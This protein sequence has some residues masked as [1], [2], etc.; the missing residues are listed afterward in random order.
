MSN[1]NL[2]ESMKPMASNLSEKAK[3]LSTKTGAA[4]SRVTRAGNDEHTGLMWYSEEEEERRQNRKNKNEK[5][6]D[7]DDGALKKPPPP[8]LNISVEDLDG[9]EDD[10][11]NSSYLELD[12][13]KKLSDLDALLDKLIRESSSAAADAARGTSSNFDR[14]VF[15]DGLSGGG[16]KKNARPRNCPEEDSRWYSHL[17]YNFANPLIKLGYKRPL[18]YEDLWDLKPTDETKESGQKLVEA[19][20][21]EQEAARKEWE[22]L[23]AARRAASEERET[24][25]ANQGR[26][27][28]E[29]EER[30]EMKRRNDEGSEKTTMD[31]WLGRLKWIQQLNGKKEKDE[32][33]MPPFL[34]RSLRRVYKQQFWRTFVLKL[35]HD[36]IMFLSPFI[37]ERL[38]HELN[39]VVHSRK[40]CF[41]LSLALLIC[42]IFENYFV[43]LYFIEL[44][45]M[46]MHLKS[47]FISLLYSKALRI[48]SAA[49]HS[50]GV[51]PIVN[52]QSNDASK[53]W[54]MPMYIHILWNG[55]FQILVVMGL[56]VRVM[57]WGPSFA[58][59]AVTITIIPA[60]MMSG[61]ALAASR[62]EQV[63]HTDAR[64]KL[65][66][67]VV[68]GIKAIK[69][70]AWENAYV[71]RILKLREQELKQIRRT[72][73]LNVMNTITFFSG[74]ILVSIAAFGTFSAMHKGRLTSSTAFPAL[75]LF[76]LLRFPILMFPSQVM[77]MIQARVSLARLQKF[78]QADEVERIS[79]SG[80]KGEEEEEG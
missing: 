61:K 7:D 58:G 66:S 49:K 79:L 73:Y 55:P 72:N 21:K 64:I 13:A 37:L 53:I 15:G 20:L 62:R 75:A 35:V 48:T 8:F 41:W 69:F 12:K 63:K 39:K 40:A 5:Y 51:G 78:F 18:D 77:G 19:L 17:L 14:D 65:C 52:L 1:S 26:S 50:I 42:S 23:K 32:V 3:A 2:V 28:G 22:Q 9:G 44:F 71:D 38:L 4:I 67:E 33:P 11:N 46:S 54:N 16:K 30:E 80:G 24:L 74:P 60:T 10:V 29:T 27:V 59:L 76:N 68:T 34:W 57:G 6:G 47:G 25:L 70:Y 31:L 56:L 45:R 43:N 36:V